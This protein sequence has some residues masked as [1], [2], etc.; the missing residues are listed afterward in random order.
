MAPTRKYGKTITEE[1]VAQGRFLLHRLIR[2]RYRDDL[3]DTVF[4]QGRPSGKKWKIELE[5]DGK[6]IWLTK[7]FGKF[8]KHYSVVCGH[9]IVLEYEGNSTFLVQ[10]YS[11]TNSDVDEIGKKEIQTLS[12]HELDCNIKKDHKFKKTMQ[13][14]YVSRGFLD[15]P[16]EFSRDCLKKEQDEVTLRN[17]DNGKTWPAMYHKTTSKSG[18]IITRL[19]NGWSKFFDDNGLKVGDE[20]EFDQLIKHDKIVFNVV[21]P[22]SV[23]PPKHGCLKNIR[24]RSGDNS[25][26]GSHKIRKRIT[27]EG[28][29]ESGRTRGSLKLARTEDDTKISPNTMDDLSDMKMIPEKFT[30]KYGSDIPSSVVLKVPTGAVWRVGVTKCDGDIWLQRGWRE[31]MK[32]YSIVYGHFLVFKCE[33]TSMFNVTIFDPTAVEIEYPYTSPIIVED[34]S[35]TNEE[36]DTQEY[37]DD[38]SVVILEDISTSSKRKGK[39]PV[40]SRKV[41]RDDSEEE[42]MMK[43]LRGELNH[44]ISKNGEGMSTFWKSSGRDNPESVKKPMT[45]ANNFKSE[46]PFLKVTMHPSYISKGYL[47]IQTEFARTYMDNER[48]EVVLRNSDGK[49][50]LAVYTKRPPAIFG[51]WGTFVKENLM[52][53]GD[54][55]VFEFIKSNK[56]MLNVVIF[57]SK[58]VQNCHVPGSFKQRKVKVETNIKSRLGVSGSSNPS[59]SE[60]VK[61]NVIMNLFFKKFLPPSFLHSPLFVPFMFFEKFSQTKEQNVRLQIA[62]RLWNVKLILDSTCRRGHLSG[63]WFLFA[64]E[65]KLE[66]GDEC[67][68][69]I[70]DVKDPLLKVSVIKKQKPDSESTNLFET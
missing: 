6:K 45:K 37:E 1:D 8:M 38:E 7:G 66:A 36:F 31:F 9:M 27:S 61:A 12:G 21:M 17:P 63:G 22:P 13:P 40:L 28:K 35:H 55:C 4:L 59:Y 68:F 29:T 39:S 50:W 53:V 32:Y 49:T 46:D 18:Q 64:R 52:K 48:G 42:T 3:Q 57:R 16:A 14:S 2:K 60:N 47:R 33:E 25:E 67:T 26:E 58:E 51:G 24:K 44:P 23:N 69:E 30:R 70:V 5:K 10:I 34:L 65:N 54:E 19:S 41:K 56:F 15:I 20:C 62:D 11:E 43:K